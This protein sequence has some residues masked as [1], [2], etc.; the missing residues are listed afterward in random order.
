MLAAQLPHEGELIPQAEPPMA[1]HR[2]EVPSEVTFSINGVEGIPLLL[3]LSK[4]QILG[5]DNAHENVF[6][7]RTPGSKVA[8]KLSVG[9]Y[10]V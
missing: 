6:V 9:S 4:Y 2:G 1:I 8:Y 5:L 10:P 3:A 7:N